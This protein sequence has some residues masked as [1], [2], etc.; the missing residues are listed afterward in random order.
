MIEVQTGQREDTRLRCAH[1]ELIGECIKYQNCPPYA[2]NGEWTPYPRKPEPAP[3]PKWSPAILGII[4]QA[5]RALLDA[6]TN[7]SFEERAAAWALIRGAFYPTE[8]DPASVGGEVSAEVR[9]ETIIATLGCYVPGGW[10]HPGEEAS[11]LV[12]GEIEV[13]ERLAHRRGFEAGQRDMQ[14]RA[15]RAVNGFT[16]E[17]RDGI[18]ASEV[19]R[20]LP[21]QPQEEKAAPE[22][23]PEKYEEYAPCPACGCSTPAHAPAPAPEPENGRVCYSQHP[24]STICNA[25][26][27]YQAPSPPSAEGGDDTVSKSVLA[28]WERTSNDP[29]MRD[30][31]LVI[32]QLREERAALLACRE[33][34]RDAI[35]TLRNAGMASERWLASADDALA[36]ADKAVRE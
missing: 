22:R 15:A 12:T 9:A 18:T 27:D 16:K 35:T 6:A 28:R 10:A 19:V 26:V 8:D 13:A 24:D 5:R 11:G 7:A 21:L 29:N 14:G 2:L 23:E 33:T 36:A 34:L 20:A 1:G 31:V 17:R 3:A 32:R 30:A 25:C 4:D